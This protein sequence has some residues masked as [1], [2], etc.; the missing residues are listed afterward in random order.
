MFGGLMGHGDLAK[1]WDDASMAH[2]TAMERKQ[3]AI[4]PHRDD[5]EFGD[6]E[7][8]AGAGAG[9]G[10]GAAES[11][12]MEGGVSDES[13]FNVA[14][15]MAIQHYNLYFQENQDDFSYM[16]EFE[17]DVHVDNGNNTSFKDGTL[18]EEIQDRFPDHF[19]D[20]FQDYDIDTMSQS[21]L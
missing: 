15:T 12:R 17:E 4:S 16:R 1:I 9:T 18:P 5:G 8:G 19:Q 21:I 10:A 14:I 6:W 3:P 20:Q 7:T 11:G 13:L 2:V